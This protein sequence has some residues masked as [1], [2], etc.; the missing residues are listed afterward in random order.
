MA[1]EYNGKIRSPLGCYIGG[2]S[3]LA[4]AIIS[5][6]PAHSCYIEPFCG[7]AWVF[8]RKS[9]SDREILNDINGDVINFYEQ[10]RDNLAGFI[11][12]T[13]FCLASRVLFEKFRREGMDGLNNLERAFRYW[14]MLKC[15]YGGRM[16]NPGRKGHPGKKA[17]Y[18]PSFSPMVSNFRGRNHNLVFRLEEVRGWHERLRNVIFE[19]QPW[20]EIIRRRDGAASFFYIDPPYHGM[21][22][23]YGPYFRRE[24]FEE[25]AVLLAGIQGRFILSINDNAATREIFRAFNIEPV[26]TTYTFNSASQQK[27]RAELLI[28]NF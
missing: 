28:T 5:R 24:E 19:A 27:R 7:G 26:G 22:S 8:F 21:E 25:M 18:E 2:K 11:A 3:R 14:Y 17:R 15:S 23:Y 10:I 9:R 1:Y 4:R 13:R 16:F 6:I 12:R 20:R